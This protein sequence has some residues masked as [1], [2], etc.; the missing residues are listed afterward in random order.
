MVDLIFTGK[1]DGCECAEL[2]LEETD[3]FY[4]SK[5]EVHC[6]HEDACERMEKKQEGEQ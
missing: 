1:C 6:T 5:W 4:G 3:M 2:E